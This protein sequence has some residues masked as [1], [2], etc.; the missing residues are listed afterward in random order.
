MEP[1]KS[2][3]PTEDGVFVGVCSNSR[4]LE[5]IAMTVVGE[6]EMGIDGIGDTNANSKT[7]DGHNLFWS[8]LWQ[9][10]MKGGDGEY[11]A[12]LLLTW[13]VNGRRGI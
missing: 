4:Q 5:L 11:L 12:R 8:Q 2:G 9:R 3:P 6:L 13:M 7:T 1:V 10:S